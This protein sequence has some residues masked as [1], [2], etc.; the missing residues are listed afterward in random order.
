MLKFINLKELSGAGVVVHTFSPS[1]Q[2]AKAVWSKNEFQDCYTEK[3]WGVQVGGRG[4][5]LNQI[6]R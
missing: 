2:E 1:T 4:I 3:S 6:Y 5:R